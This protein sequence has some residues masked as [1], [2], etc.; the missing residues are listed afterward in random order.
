MEME[1]EFKERKEEAWQLQH[2]P[3]AS[4][5]AYNNNFY[6]NK[7]DFFFFWVGRPGFRVDVLTHGIFHLLF[8]KRKYSRERERE[9]WV[10]RRK[11]AVISSSFGLVGEINKLGINSVD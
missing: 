8:V 2:H 7:I 9:F 1:I 4:S 3:Q 11:V 10:L 5:P 6:N